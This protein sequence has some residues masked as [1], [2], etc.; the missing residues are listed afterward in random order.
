VNRPSILIIDDD[1]ETGD[2]V[3]DALERRADVDETETLGR[4]GLEGVVFH[5][6]DAVIVTLERLDGLG[7]D[8]AA[9]DKTSSASDRSPA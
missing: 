1:P 9:A 5:P 7:L 8:R 4:T 2:A 3:G 6:A